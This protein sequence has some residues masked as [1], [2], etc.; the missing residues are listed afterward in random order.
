LGSIDA[1]QI[2]DGELRFGIH[3]GQQHTDFPSYLAMW[4]TAEDLGL[5]WASVFDH[6]VPI[7]SDPEG[8]CFDG[9]TLLAALA[10]HT[11][12]IR[13]GVLVT[14]VTYRHPAVLANMA[15]TIDHVSGGRLELGMGA[16]WFELEHDQY[17]IAFPPIAERAEMLREAAL[18]C[19]SMWT[20]HRTTFDGEHFRLRDA[21]CLP[22]PVPQQSIPLWVGGAGERRTLRVTAEVADGWNTFLMPEEEYRHKLDVLAEH[23][24]DLGRDANDI[25]KSLVVGVILGETERDA[26]ERLGERAQVMHTT[27]DALRERF[28]AV[29]PERCAEVLEPYRD[30]GVG[31]FLMMARP[32]A[33]VRTMEL[34]RGGRAGPPRLAQ[35]ER[36]PDPARLLLSRCGL[37]AAPAQQDGGNGDRDD[38]DEQHDSSQGVDGRRDPEPH[39]RVQHDR[40]RVRRAVRERR[41]DVVVERKGERE[42]P[43][44]HDRRHQPR[45]RDLTERRERSGSQVVGGLFQLVAHADEPGPDDEHGDRRVEHDLAEQDRALAQR[46]E[47]VHVGPELHKEDERRYRDDDLGYH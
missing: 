20:N 12:R 14:G 37:N 33:D 28:L 45:K 29:T 7:Y 8:P 35:T 22:K 10:A 40:P 43:G 17:G 41:K 26:E 19:R 6:F 46:R 39:R 44:R 21:L 25:R 4:R 27:V 11:S 15:A 34:F 18:I 1:V 47:R 16:A 31:D 42:Q 3:A 38:R 13:C 23:C 9:Q 32:P 24:K 5:D 30:L 2:F 36:R